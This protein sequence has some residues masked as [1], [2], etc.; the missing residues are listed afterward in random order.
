MRGAPMPDGH[1]SQDADLSATGLEGYAPY[2]MNRIMGRYNANMRD[3]LKALGLTTAKMRTLAVLSVKG[4][5]PISALAVFAVVEQS[6]LSRALEGLLAEGLIRREA[7]AEDGRS[8]RIYL[9]DAG[10]AAFDRLW[11]R[12]SA[13]HDAMFDGIDAPERAAFLT[14]LSKM[15]SNIRVHDL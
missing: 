9:T 3:E 14:T 4:G 2:L 15:L 5:L 8:S 13:E 1:P 12:M 11:P 6:T 10:H 7:D